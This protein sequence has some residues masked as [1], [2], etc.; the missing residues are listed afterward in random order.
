MELAQDIGAAIREQRRRRGMTQADLALLAGVGRRFVSELENAK[1]TVRL[2]EVQRVLAVFGL[3]LA[4]R[5]R[6][7]SER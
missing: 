1:P 2:E 3:T 7:R 5:G 4:L 6:D